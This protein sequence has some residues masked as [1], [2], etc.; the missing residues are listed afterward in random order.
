M[1]YN[2]FCTRYLLIH[3][4]NL[5]YYNTFVLQGLNLFPIMNF[6]SKIFVND[7]NIMQEKI[8]RK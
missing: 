6:K 1:D 3:E 8:G 7:N 2:I 4:G 5:C